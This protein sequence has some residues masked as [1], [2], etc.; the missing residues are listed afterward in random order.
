MEEYFKSQ[1]ASSPGVQADALAKGVSASDLRERFAAFIS[2]PEDELL[3]NFWHLAIAGDGLDRATSQLATS[4][5]CTINAQVVSLEND[6]VLELRLPTAVVHDKVHLLEDR[7]ALRATLRVPGAIGVATVTAMLTRCA[8]P[9][10]ET[11]AMLRRLAAKARAAPGC[12]RCDV[13]ISDDWTFNYQ[14]FSCP[15]SMKHAD[16]RGLSMCAVVRALADEGKVDGNSIEHFEG[17][18]LEYNARSPPGYGVGSIGSG[19]N[20]PPHMAPLWA[21]INDIELH[22]ESD[23]ESFIE[24]ELQ[25]AQSA[26]TVSQCI[27]YDVLQSVESPHILMNFQVFH[28]Q[29][30]ELNARQVRRITTSPNIMAAV[31]TTCQGV[32]SSI[33]P[34]RGMLRSSITSSASRNSSNR[35]FSHRSSRHSNM[36]NVANTASTASESNIST[37]CRRYT[38]FMSG[39]D[40]TSHTVASINAC[41]RQIASFADGKTKKNGRVTVKKISTLRMWEEFDAPKLHAHAAVIL[42]DA[43]KVSNDSES[44]QLSP[45]LQLAATKVQRIWRNANFVVKH[46]GAT[47]LRRPNG[48][49]ADYGEICFPGAMEMP[50]AKYAVV[51]DD[52]S[53]QMLANVMEKYWKMSRPEVILTVMGSAANFEL[54]EQL[55]PIFDRG[56]VDAAKNAKATIFCGGT[57]SGVIRL[58]GQALFEGNVCFNASK[59]GLKH[60]TW[61]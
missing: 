28:S 8:L 40:F 38:G 45:L 54:S 7:K 39:T 49:P 14:V 13:V 34:V 51:H 17:R 18:A 27:R 55:Q 58:V 5:E 52:S 25:R 33:N 41:I 37:I 32:R 46:Y 12:L 61:H 3:R 10:D 9:G 50:P 60:D 6:P 19:R 53:P 56:L 1:I 42:G 29:R 59:K 15:S 11:L 24:A 23:T 43:Y 4:R 21:V 35:G 48:Q 2:S 44:Q 36:E 31:S 16:K 47:L 26:L 20:D 22:N 30:D 57:D